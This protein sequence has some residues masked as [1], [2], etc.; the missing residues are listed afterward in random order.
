MS[1]LLSARCIAEG[2]CELVKLFLQLF[3]SAT[4]SF[5]D[6]GIQNLNLNVSPWTMR[7]IALCLAEKKRQN[8]LCATIKTVLRLYEE[9]LS[10]ALLRWSLNLIL[11]LG[12]S[13]PISGWR[14]R[15]HLS[16]SY[17]RVVFLVAL[18]L[19]CSLSLVFCSLCLVPS[20]LPLFELRIPPETNLAVHSKHGISDLCHKVISYWT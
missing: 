10:F 8:V 18:L 6:D 1:S 11:S 16:L 4:W 7:W 12:T 9:L 20:R 15:K 19:L 3:L 2:D 17:K 13:S 5:Y 14:P